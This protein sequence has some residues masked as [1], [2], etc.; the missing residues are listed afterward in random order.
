[1]TN[2]RTFLEV[3]PALKQ[4]LETDL[5]T[6]VEAIQETIP[7]IV[8]KAKE[9][10]SPVLD[11]IDATGEALLE[12][13]K[14]FVGQG[15]EKLE[16]GLEKIDE[17]GEALLDQATEAFQEGK[18]LFDEFFGGNAPKKVELLIRETEKEAKKLQKDTA[19]FHKRPPKKKTEA[20]QSKLD[21]RGLI[22]KEKFEQIK[23]FL[24]NGIN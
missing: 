22:L 24:L 1:M 15:L 11:K 6:A 12:K 9:I 18:R 7:E 21:E 8:G 14:D 17:T 13:A 5:A 19:A 3:E 20:A 23:A 10:V 4:Q 16:Q 2:A